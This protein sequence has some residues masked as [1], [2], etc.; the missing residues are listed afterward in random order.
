MRSCHE[1]DVTDVTDVTWQG[2][3]VLNSYAKILN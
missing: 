1:A 3:D 2:Y